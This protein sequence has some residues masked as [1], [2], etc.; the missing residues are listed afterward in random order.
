MWSFFL[1]QRPF[2]GLSDVWLSGDGTRCFLDLKAHLS[3]HTHNS[4]VAA[5][6]PD[7]PA[8]S[9]HA[10]AHAHACLPAV[11]QPAP[12]LESRHGHGPAPLHVCRPGHHFTSRD[13]ASTRTTAGL[14]LSVH[15]YKMSEIGGA[16]GR[17]PQNSAVKQEGHH[18]LPIGARAH[19]DQSGWWATRSA[20]RRSAL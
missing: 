1:F 17:Q 13:V 2:R 20:M 9:P 15:V 19:A 16:A 4:S 7:D 10:H 5:D 11:M 3:V 18:E 12:R 8:P 6:E 14:T